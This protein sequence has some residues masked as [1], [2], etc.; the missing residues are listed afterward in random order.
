MWYE[1]ELERLGHLHYA[2]FLLLH[3]QKA[4]MLGGSA[5]T[6]AA[7]PSPLVE[8]P[9]GWSYGDFWYVFLRH[10]ERWLHYPFRSID[11]L[12][13]FGLFGAYGPIRSA[14]GTFSTPLPSHNDRKFRRN[15][16]RDFFALLWKCQSHF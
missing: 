14:Y 10:Q 12:G 8:D 16:R 5:Y 2:P 9:S 3:P 4:T 1:E 15:S 11:D 13:G 6:A 7:V